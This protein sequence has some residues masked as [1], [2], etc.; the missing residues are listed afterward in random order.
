LRR[1]VTLLEFAADLIG[2]EL[3]IDYGRVV[4]RMAD[5]RVASADI[6]VEAR[7]FRLLETFDPR[8]AIAEWRREALALIDDW[9]RR[10]K[11]T[12]E[13]GAPPALTTTVS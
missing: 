13:R 10:L 6:E 7:D 11:L 12:E 9:V 5:E 3:V 4:L 1:F 2:K 8:T